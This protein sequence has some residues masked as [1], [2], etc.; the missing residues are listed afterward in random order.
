MRRYRTMAAERE[1]AKT[2]EPMRPLRLLLIVR[3]PPPKGGIARWTLL[4]MGWLQGQGEVLF[5]HV[6][7]AS[8]WRALDDPSIP[9]QLVLGMLQGFHDAWRVLVQLVRF[10]PDVI[11]LTT[12]GGMAGM[13][14]IVFMCLARLFRVPA[15]YHIHF[16]RIPELVKSGGWEWQLLRRAMRMAHKVVVI[17]PKTGLALKEILPPQKLVLVPN[18]IVLEGIP[19]T[20]TSASDRTKTVYFLGWVVPTKGIRELM[21]AWQAVDRPGWELK[22]AGPGD[23]A[24]RQEMAGGLANGAKV[25]FL[26]E[27]SQ[28]QGWNLMQEAD[29]FIL[30]SY[31]EGFPYVILEA[32]AAGKAIVATRVGAI[33]D[34]LD[35]ETAYPCGLLVEPK[36]PRALGEVLSLVMSDSAL[37]SELGRRARAKVE[38]SYDARMVFGRYLE[39]WRGLASNCRNPHRK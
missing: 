39:I 31:T 4:V 19:P 13:R 15:V 5:R 28:S 11:H 34:M 1:V 24:Y 8:R 27:L 7:T 21:E 23:R 25:Q 35:A 26:G 16:G 10:Q 18:G 6:D 12:S 29:I 36:E 38:R 3:K 9:K 14:D 17:D 33:P 30:P 20:K 37:R 22:V 32:M 2:D